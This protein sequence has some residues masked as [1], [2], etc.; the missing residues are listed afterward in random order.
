[1]RDPSREMASPRCNRPQQRHNRPLLSTETRPFTHDLCT[2]QET[3]K[4]LEDPEQQCS[5]RVLA[6]LGKK[7]SGEGRRISARLVR[8]DTKVRQRSLGVWY[9]PELRENERGSR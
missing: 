9:E 3:E 1:M 6:T 8:E 4:P 5:K 7:V 2:A